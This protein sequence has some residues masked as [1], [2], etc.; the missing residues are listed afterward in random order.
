M[1][2]L[3]PAIHVFL[4]AKP[5]LRSGFLFDPIMRHVHACC[6][7]P[8]M[9]SRRIKNWFALRLKYIIKYASRVLWRIAHDQI[10]AGSFKRNGRFQPSTCSIIMRALGAICLRIFLALFATQMATCYSSLAALLTSVH[11]SELVFTQR[12]HK[13][14]GRSLFI[15]ECAKPLWP[16]TFWRRSTPP[17]AA[18]VRSAIVVDV[19]GRAA[20][21]IADWVA[22]LVSSDA[23]AQILLTLQFSK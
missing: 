16:S 14:F 10:P 15:A 8:R 22:K 19:S 6:R 11:S 23:L 18:F 7:H 21:N 3:V 9:Q 12:H 2:G 4:K 20:V 13:E 17:H 5:R 1:A